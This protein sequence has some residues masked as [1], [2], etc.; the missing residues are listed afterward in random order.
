MKSTTRILMTLADAGLGALAIAL[1][2]GMPAQAATILY[3]DD[4]ESDALGAAPAGW[5]AS[6][7]T[8]TVAMD[9]SH[10]MKQTDTNTATAKSIQAGSAAWTD[11]AVQ[12]QPLTG[13]RPCQF[14]HL[15]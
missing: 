15:R 8:W 1:E 3:A 12:A 9:G 2:T 10:V 5:T 14:E 4:F 6:A 7:G 11:Y 13:V